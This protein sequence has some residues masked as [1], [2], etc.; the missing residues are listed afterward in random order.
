MIHCIEPDVNRVQE[1]YDNWGTDEKVWKAMS[2][3]PVDSHERILR[4]IR[5]SKNAMELGEFYRFMIIEE[6]TNQAIGFATYT[7]RQGAME[8]GLSIG[9]KF[10]GKGYGSRVL[11]L[12]EQS[13]KS[14]N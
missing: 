3:I 2:S 11:K 1:M 13:L 7:P 12:A 4:V 8:V 6:E 10:W 9:S 14:W 5:H